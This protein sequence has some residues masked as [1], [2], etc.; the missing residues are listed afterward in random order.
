[1]NELNTYSYLLEKYH[2]LIGGVGGGEDATQD[3]KLACDGG[4]AVCDGERQ[5]PICCD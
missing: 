5:S 2:H 4:R 1:M 3:Q